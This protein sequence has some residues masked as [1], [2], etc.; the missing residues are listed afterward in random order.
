MFVGQGRGGNGDIPTSPIPLFFLDMCRTNI[1]FTTLFP[2]NIQE[3][4]PLGKYLNMARRKFYLF[5]EI[6]ML[7]RNAEKD[8]INSRIRI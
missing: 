2:S 4:N 3:E 8:R 7:I 1:K 6:P 5:R